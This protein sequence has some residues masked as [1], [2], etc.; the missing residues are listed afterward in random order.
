ML[1]L[2]DQ[3]LKTE[4]RAWV[5]YSCAQEAEVR[6]DP[7]AT[8]VFRKAIIHSISRKGLGILLNTAVDVGT[9]LKVG[10]QGFNW[11]R[12]LLARVVRVSA[13]PDGWYHGCELANILTEDEVEEILA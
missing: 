3:L 10:L 9:I 7:A 2:R 5:R 1:Q 8:V 4:R 12:L 13:Q 6:P 11:S